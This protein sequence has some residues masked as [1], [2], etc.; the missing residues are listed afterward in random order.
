MT[1]SWA[2]WNVPFDKLRAG[3]RG[4]RTKPGD[5][6]QSVVGLG[7]TG[8]REPE[9]GRTKRTGIRGYALVAAF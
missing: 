1:P 9:A 7:V 6:G 5:K 2:Y 3:F 4:R 8:S